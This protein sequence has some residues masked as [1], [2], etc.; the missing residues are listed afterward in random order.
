MEFGVCKSNN[1]TKNLMALRIFLAGIKIFPFDETAAI[2]YGN[3]RATLERRGTP[4]GA[5]DLLIAAH[6]RSLNL[7]L[8]TNNLKE[9]NRVDGLRVENWI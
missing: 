2:E 6:A 8:I 3:I 7:T 9:F 1:V 5:N 4:I